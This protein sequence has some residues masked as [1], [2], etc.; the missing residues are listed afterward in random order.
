MPA[1]RHGEAPAVGL[2]EQL[3]DAGLRV[4]RLTALVAEVRLHDL[5]KM[6]AAEITLDA[7]K[8]AVNKAG[9]GRFEGIV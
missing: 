2:S 1:G 8:D 6:D 7:L 5:Q 3:R 9:A 4:A